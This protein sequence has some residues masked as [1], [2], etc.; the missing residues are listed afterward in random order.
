VKRLQ[1]GFL[2]ALKILWAEAFLTDKL[3]PWRRLSVLACLRG[4]VPPT[5]SSVSHLCVITV[6]RRP[7]NT[8]LHCWRPCFL[9]GSDP[10]ID[11]FA[12]ARLCDVG[13]VITHVQM[14]PIF[15]RSY[16]SL[17]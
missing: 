4:L 15:A 11:H 10:G 8:T 5:V 3:S 1:N 7:V 16:L 6:P 14:A 2:A 17:W 12:F 9:R 13:V